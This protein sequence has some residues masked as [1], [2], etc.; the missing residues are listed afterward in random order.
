MKTTI[1]WAKVRSLKAGVLAVS[2]AGAAQTRQPEKGHAY[3]PSSHF[4]VL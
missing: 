2:H 3:A 1:L 4:R